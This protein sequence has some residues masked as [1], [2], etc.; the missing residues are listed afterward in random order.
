VLFIKNDITLRFDTTTAAAEYF[1]N[2]GISKR[3]NIKSL[4]QDITQRARENKTLFG[5]KVYYESKR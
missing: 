1:I 2:N 4:R 3:K 5:F